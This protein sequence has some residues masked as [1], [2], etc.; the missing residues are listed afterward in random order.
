MTADFTKPN[1]IMLNLRYSML[2]QLRDKTKNKE[3][4]PEGKQNLVTYYPFSC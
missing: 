2:S 1:K 4:Q 3:A